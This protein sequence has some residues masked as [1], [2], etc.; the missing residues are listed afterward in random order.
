LLNLDLGR[1]W[2]GQT[3]SL[4]GSQ[5]TFLALPVSAA[6]VLHSTPLEMGILAACQWAPTLLVA[7]AFCRNAAAR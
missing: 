3:V 6:V 4:L 5:V 7:R 2:I 1:V